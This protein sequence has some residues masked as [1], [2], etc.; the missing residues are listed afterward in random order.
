MKKLL[1]LLVLALLLCGCVAEPPEQTT[2]PQTTTLPPETT[3]P[4][5]PV[6]GLYIP[7][8]AVEQQTG[9]AVKEYSLGEDEYANGMVMVGDDLLL[10]TYSEAGTRL[11]LLSGENGVVTAQRMAGGSVNVGGALM[12]T[13]RNTIAY[14]DDGDRSVVFLDKT[15]TETE[16]VRMPED[17]EGYPVIS[18]DL[19]KIYYCKPGKICQLDL[20]TGIS[21]LL[22]QQDAQWLYVN[23]I[24]FDG[25][26][27][28]YSVTEYDD[29]SY[30]GFLSTETGELLGMDTEL[31]SIETGGDAFLV[32]RTN[33]YLD[34]YLVGTVGGEVYAFTGGSEEYLCGT[35]TMNGFM[36]IAE[37]EGGSKISVYDLRTG[38]RTAAVML[39]EL[40]GVGTVA[41][42]AQQ[43]VLWLLGYDYDSNRERLYRW[44]VTMSAVEDET[45]Y[46][47]KRYTRENPDAEGLAAV[48]QLADSLEEKYKVQ[49]TLADD[50]VEPWD[51][52][53]VTEFRPEALQ[54][55]LETLDAALSIYPEGYLTK[56]VSN[57]EAEVVQI[58]IVRDISDDAVGLQYWI[59]GNAYIALEIGW[60]LEQ[61]VHHE[62]CHVLDNIV[63]ANSYAYDDWEDL[64]PKGFTYDYSY[65]EYQYRDGWQYLSGEEQA[66]IDTYSMTYPKEDRARIME[67]AAMPDNEY[68]FQSDIM[69]KKLLQICKGIRECFGYE[70]Y[71]GTF[72]WEQYLETSL[73]YTKKK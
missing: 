62:L 39:Q 22:R 52:T 42:D 29:S 17:M 49:I 7:D 46:L 50:V 54:M 47:G 59:D 13:T 56:L 23:D 65:D 36:G 2:D 48:R 12:Q 27:L 73:A 32:Q 28:E 6:P 5:E 70:K 31:W 3:E 35:R 26:M 58:A 10:I 20:N 55:G 30:T 37:T 60:D 18:P 71:E 61:T 21:R 53:F 69:Q 43:Q 45:V 38:R 34:E 66:F 25:T 72:L 40:D 63:I 4:T 11:Q 68:Y 8:S 19:K 64:N 67:Y 41:E 15:L 9:G 14:Y 51:Y 24:H 1:I 16:R 44:D 33:G 57:T